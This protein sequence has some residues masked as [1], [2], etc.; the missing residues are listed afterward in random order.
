MGSATLR[1]RC[2]LVD[3][4]A[5]QWMMKLELGSV[6]VHQPGLLGAIKRLRADAEPC[7][8]AQ[9]RGKL[10]AVVGGADVTAA[11]ASL[12]AAQHTRVRKARSTRALTGSGSTSGS[13]PVSCASLNN[14]GQLQQGEWVA[15][16]RRDEPVSSFRRERNASAGDRVAHRRHPGRARPTAARA[17]LVHQ[18]AA[19]RVRVR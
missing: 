13:T 4:R 1:K 16:G 12:A 8:G 11:S 19:H 17:A 7:R 3:R 14:A 5:H 2:P 18:S 15:T 10:T 9:D 6:Q